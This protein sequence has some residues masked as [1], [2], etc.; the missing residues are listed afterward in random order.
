M[1]SGQV[2]LGCCS[3]GANFPKSATRSSKYAA[4][5]RQS[6][7]YLVILATSEVLRLSGRTKCSKAMAKGANINAGSLQRT[8][9]AND[10]TVARWNFQEPLSN[11]VNN[12][13]VS[14]TNSVT[15]SS[16]TAAIQSTTSVCTGWIAKSAAASQSRRRAR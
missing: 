4:A 6:G 3:T 15:S 14:R 13:N 11:W 5:T 16:G 8:A 1:A 12:Q 9:S 10:I 7:T 2:T